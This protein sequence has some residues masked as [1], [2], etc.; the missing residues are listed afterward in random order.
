MMDL[1]Q[2]GAGFLTFAS[3]ILHCF[4]RPKTAHQQVSRRPFVAVLPRSHDLTG[5]FPFELYNH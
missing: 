4:P 5:R 3:E 2:P 1:A